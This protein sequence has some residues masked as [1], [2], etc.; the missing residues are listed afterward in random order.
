MSE[1]LQTIKEALY[2]GADEIAIFF[3]D[4][5]PEDEAYEEYRER[6]ELM[7]KAKAALERLIDEEKNDVR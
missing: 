6:T 1:D 5:T 4:L 2:F 7:T 3:D